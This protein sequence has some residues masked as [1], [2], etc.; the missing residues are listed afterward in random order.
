MLPLQYNAFATVAR[1]IEWPEKVLIS[2]G[3]DYSWGDIPP[4]NKYKE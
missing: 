2:Y 3:Y 1:G 4:K